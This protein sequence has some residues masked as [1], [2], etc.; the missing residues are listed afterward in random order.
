ML[1]AAVLIVMAD[2]TVLPLINTNINFRLPSHKEAVE[3]KKPEKHAE[4]SLPSLSDYIIV[5]EENLF[6]P[7]RKIP[8]EKKAEEKPVPKPEFVLYGTLIANNTSLAYLEDLKAPKTTPGRGNRQIVLKEGDALS[9][10][11]LKEVDPD[12]VVMVRGEEKMTVY[13]IEPGKPKARGEAPPAVQ[14]ARGQHVQ[15]HRRTF[16]SASPSKSTLPRSLLHQAPPVPKTRAPL[17]P[18][19]ERARQFFERAR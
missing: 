1:L 13:V 11:T 19:D 12:K 6:H 18:G 5:G 9:G 17:T 15:V 8:T 7:E 3:V 10:Y 14:G 4:D 2:Y 16:S